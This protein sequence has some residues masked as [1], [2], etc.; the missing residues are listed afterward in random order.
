M[1]LQ[2]CPSGTMNSEVC[3]CMWGWVGTCVYVEGGVG[4]GTCVYTVYNIML[5]VLAELSLDS[6][7]YFRTFVEFIDNTFPQEGHQI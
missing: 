3:V 2:D 6:M 4:V 1:F 5:F 7:I